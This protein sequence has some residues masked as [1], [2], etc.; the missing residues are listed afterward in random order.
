MVSS[1]RSIHFADNHRIQ[2]AAGKA[3]PVLE[4]EVAMDPVLPLMSQVLPP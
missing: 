4:I 3:A 1:F 2:P